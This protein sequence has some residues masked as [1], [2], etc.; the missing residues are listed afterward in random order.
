[1]KTNARALD[2]QAVNL[3]NPRKD[4]KPPASARKSTQIRQSMPVSWPGA[5]NHAAAGGRQG[6]SLVH[7][8]VEPGSMVTRSCQSRRYKEFPRGGAGISVRKGRGKGGAR[9]VKG[10]EW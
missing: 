7:N 10:L 3:G 8:R 2:P 5:V 4:P 9:L 1:M 6:R